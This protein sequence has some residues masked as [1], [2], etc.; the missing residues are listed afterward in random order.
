MNPFVGTKF[1]VGGCRY[2]SCDAGQGAECVKRIEA[3]VESKREFIE[4][5]L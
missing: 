2:V 4:V 3:T 1:G 5:G